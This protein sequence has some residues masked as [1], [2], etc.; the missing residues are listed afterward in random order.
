MNFEEK[1]ILNENIIVDATQNL[2]VFNAKENEYEEWTSLFHGEIGELVDGNLS[3]NY[4]VD[5]HKLTKLK[6][7]NY[8]I[9]AELYG[10][11]MGDGKTFML[12]LSKTGTIL[13]KS[14][15]K[16]YYERVYHMINPHERIE[17]V[18]KI[19]SGEMIS[20]FTDGEENLWMNKYNPNNRIPTN[21]YL[22]GEG[23]IEELHIKY[24]ENY[25]NIELSDFIVHTR[26]LIKQKIMV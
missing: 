11:L 26:E 3:S 13:K 5:V 10:T 12:L 9:K 4:Y 14:N 18:R 22:L 20:E 17:I 1:V 21:I 7:G 23:T 6:S 24:I 15:L 2:Y 19:N 25:G 8:K 16:N